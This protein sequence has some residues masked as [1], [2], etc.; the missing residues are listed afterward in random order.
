[1]SIG[2]NININININKSLQLAIGGFFIAIITFSVAYG[3]M[4]IKLKES[5]KEQFKFVASSFK[6]PIEEY[7]KVAS[8]KEK[9]IEHELYYVLKDMNEELKD[10]PF[11][12]ISNE[13]IVTLK[14]KYGLSE[15]AFLQ[16]RNDGEIIIGKSSIKEEEG[17]KTSKWGYW[18]DAFTQLFDKKEV[19]IGR[20]YSKD[21]YWIGPKSY[22]YTNY[23]QNK[24]KKYYKFAYYLNEEQGY[25]ING[26]IKEEEYNQYGTTALNNLLEEFTDRVDGINEISILNAKAWK[27][28][29]D[30]ESND[31][32]IIYGNM[33]HGDFISMNI[34][35]YNISS[36]KEIEFIK[37]SL[38][39][40][41]V[42]SVFIPI[43]NELYISLILKKNFLESYDIKLI[44]ILL[45]VSIIISL[46]IS[47]IVKNKL[48]Q[49]ENLLE[50]EKKRLQVI[51]EFKDAVANVP[52]CIFRYKVI[53]NK[54]YL[55][56]KDG[57]TISEDNYVALKGELI[58]MEEKMDFNFINKNKTKLM[59]AY[60][61]G[62]KQNFEYI[63]NEKFL[64]VILIPLKNKTNEGHIVSE[65]VGFVNDI[66]KY[67]KDNKD[68]VYK[69]YHDELTGAYNRYM[70][71]KD[72]EALKSEL[73][74]FEV[75]YLDLDGF[76][77]VN[78]KLGHKTGDKIL[79]NI[80]DRM[81]NVLI[82]DRIYR[83]GG[84]EFVIL[85]KYI[86]EDE[87]LKLV[88]KIIESVNMNIELEGELIEVGVSVG[89][90]K[91]PE[92]G[93]SKEEL[94]RISDEKMYS[95]KSMK[96]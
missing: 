39:G 82:E 55:T 52:D 44:I 49:Y 45:F 21:Q 86:G 58:P 9:E 77:S 5:E 56:Y 40:K 54:M 15:V 94:L 63:M 16:R 53:N 73:E 62:E 13:L 65:V 47:V 59:K 85:A 12:E 38:N 69:A 78:D 4:H 46:I 79:K 72:F 24:M 51:E 76:K 29:Y 50:V 92:D 10:I 28:F 84:D 25:L 88:K 81:K 7:Y 60:I 66:T 67:M 8:Q 22:A 1:M 19:V 35:P 93:T 18:Y 71:N 61:L 33:I 90:A 70:F 26:I 41:K 23:K 6:I 95:V 42:C 2:K 34:S 48:E 43:N 91:Y 17:T 64:D 74:E 37:T 83:V 3:F 80:V 96:R 20:G 87:N 89:R 57:R 14:D 36:E 68:S 31:P 75:L 30:G 11:H 27:E 32:F